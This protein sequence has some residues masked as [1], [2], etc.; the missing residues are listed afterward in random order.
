MTVT[1]P[2]LSELLAD[3]SFDQPIWWKDLEVFP[4]RRPNGH[5]PTCA[6]ID[7]LLERDEAEIA[8]TSEGGRV[9]TIKVLN[10]SPHDALILDGTELHG[11]RQNRMVNLTI[12]AGRGTETF[13]PVSCVE[14]GR[15]SYRSRRFSSSKRTVASRLRNLKAHH[16]AQRLACSGAPTADQGEVWA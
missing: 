3:V 8:E 4:L 10:K 6:L 14:A 12:I 2:V 5:A 1:V 15:W 16:V 13:I 11:A 7:E 9:P